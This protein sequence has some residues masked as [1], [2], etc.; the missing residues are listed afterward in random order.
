M[1]NSPRIINSLVTLPNSIGA[2]RMVIPWLLH[3]N[4]VKQMEN[5]EKWE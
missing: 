3:E 4:E 5:M 2:K 1:P